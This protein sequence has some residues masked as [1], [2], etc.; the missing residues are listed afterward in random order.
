MAHPGQG[1]G[2]PH[3]F[4]GCLQAELLLLEHLANHGM[5]D[6]VPQAFHFRCKLPQAFASPSHWRHRIAARIRL[7]QPQKIAQ[8]A[9]VGFLE[10]FATA[11]WLT[12]APS[13]EAPAN[14]ISINH[15]PKTSDENESVSPKKTNAKKILLIPDRPYRRK[16]LLGR[17]EKK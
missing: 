11:A 7:D 16:P 13:L 1:A 3:A 12:H 14:S 17:Q 4:C 9:F 2:R 8:K 15:P 10:R 5:A 6:L